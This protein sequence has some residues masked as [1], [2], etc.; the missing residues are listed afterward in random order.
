M[1]FFSVELVGCNE[2]APYKKI[3]THGFVMDENGQKMSKSLGNVVEPSSI[4][5]G[6]AFKDAPSKLGVDGLRLWVAQSDFRQNIVASAETLKATDK[7]YQRFRNC[8]RFAVGNLHDYEPTSLHK[9]PTSDVKFLHIPLGPV[10]MYVLKELGDLNTAVYE[11]YTENNYARALKRMEFFAS[12]VISGIYYQYCKDILY[13]DAKNSIQ[14][15]CC[16]YLLA[17]VRI[18]LLLLSVSLKMVFNFLIRA[19]IE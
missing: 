9:N 1:L 16:Q 13:A 2:S 5:N 12:V 18:Y 8:I 15:K 17:Q 14:R 11:D 4:I 3:I 6:T 10:E 19:E 7:T